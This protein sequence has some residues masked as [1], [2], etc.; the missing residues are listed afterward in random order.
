MP[1]TCLTFA[2]FALSLY[3]TKKKA[4]SVLVMKYSCRWILMVMLV[5]GNIEEF[6]F[7]LSG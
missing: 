1:F 7:Y 5:E 3:L 6:T 2:F 4:I